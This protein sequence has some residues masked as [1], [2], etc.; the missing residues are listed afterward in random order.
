MALL[1]AS[2][3]GGQSDPIGTASSSSVP[4]TAAAPVVSE[5]V[6]EFD[7]NLPPECGA[8]DPPP[9]I[10]DPRVTLSIAGGA[11]LQPQ[12][13]VEFEIDLD[14]SLEKWSTNATAVECWTGEEWISAWVAGGLFALT[15]GAI[16]LH[17]DLGIED[18]GIPDL[19]GHLAIADGAPPGIYRMLFDVNLRQAQYADDRP[20]E[21]L[22]QHF[23][24][25]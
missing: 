21:I 20:Q 17:P 24:V 6:E 25:R 23:E 19:S 15:P 9:A 1:A 2:C 16:E 18:I 14:P 4:T 13:I 7:V 11:A 10:V 5:P 3:S 8:Y 12:D 22:E